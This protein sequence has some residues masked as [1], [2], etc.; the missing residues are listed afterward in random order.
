MWFDVEQIQET[1]LRNEGTAAKELWF[2][3]E[4]IQETTSRQCNGV[5]GKLWFDVEQIQETTMI[6]D[7]LMNRPLWFDVEQI[8]ETTFAV[9]HS[10]PNY[11]GI[12]NPTIPSNLG[13]I[14]KCLVIP[15]SEIAC[16]V[17]M[18]IYI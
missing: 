13:L 7:E 6:I 15:R 3:V 16:K 4:Q 18:L 10:K 11:C 1:T 5:V 9:E 2:D 12:C 8:Q 17:L 14:Q